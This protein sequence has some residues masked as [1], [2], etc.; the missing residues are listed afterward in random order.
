MDALDRD[1]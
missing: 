1:S